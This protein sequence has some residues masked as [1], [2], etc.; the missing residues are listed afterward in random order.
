MEIDTYPKNSFLV[1][2]MKMGYSLEESEALAILAENATC[3]YNGNIDISEAIQ[4]FFR[5]EQ[6]DQRSHLPN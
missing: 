5:S 4:D 3:S 2:F 1:D 6:Y